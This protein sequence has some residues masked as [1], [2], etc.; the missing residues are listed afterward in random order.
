M[1]TGG[2]SK[3]WYKKRRYQF[4]I[5]V[6]AV[7]LLLPLIPYHSRAPSTTSQIALNKTIGYFAHNY[8]AT[9]GLIPEFPGSH[10]VWLY[11][12][13]FLAALA[14]SR[15]DSA[16]RSTTNFAAVLETVLGG[17]RA[18]LPA[19]LLQNQYTALNST[20]TSFKCSANY[21]L[22]WSATTGANLTGGTTALKTTANDQSATCSLENYADL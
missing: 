9:L 6:L 18:T 1:E 15:Y 11:S 2:A 10:T 22:S 20:S 3:P 21:V 12:D 17:Y 13:N 8:N 7:L 19:S 16:N 4:L 14:I 5:V